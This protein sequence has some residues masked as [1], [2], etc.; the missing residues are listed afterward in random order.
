MVV[1]FYIFVNIWFFCFLN[2]IKLWYGFLRWGGGLSLVLR[3]DER[4][5]EMLIFGFL[6][7]VFDG[8]GIF[9]DGEWVGFVEVVVDGGVDGVMDE[10]G[11]VLEVKR[12]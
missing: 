10:V 6:V 2:L 5:L 9:F 1:W 4:M 8:F 11:C 3:L 12:Y 7:V